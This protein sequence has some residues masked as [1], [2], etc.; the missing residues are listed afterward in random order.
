MGGS[1]QNVDF[2]RPPLGLV[3]SLTFPPKQVFMA[4]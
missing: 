3:H 2:I 1:F 4:V